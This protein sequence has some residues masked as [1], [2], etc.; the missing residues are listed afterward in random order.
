MYKAFTSLWSKPTTPTNNKI[1]LPSDFQVDEDDWVLVS[2]TNSVSKV[3]SPH[4]N[5]GLM[6]N[7]WIESPPTMR[8]GQSPSI[9]RSSSPN[10]HHFNPIENLLIEHA[11]MSVYEQIAS[12]TRA[13]R[14][15]K[16]VN[17]NKLDE[18]A[19]DVEDE[20]EDDDDDDRS[21]VV[22]QYPSQ[23][24]ILSSIH[25]RNLTASLSHSTNSSISP[26]E[27]ST[28]SLVAHHR[29]L[30]RIH[31]RRRRRSVKTS[32]KLT[33]TNN[34]DEQKQT[35]NK[36]IERQ[37]LNYARAPKFVLHQPSRSNH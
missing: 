30:H 32:S 22:L 10:I 33:L 18:Q 25:H 4:D 29:H 24:P 14:Q 13:R 8:S 37:R 16:T 21:S 15:R 23:H 5:N 35:I 31:Q 28:S 2:A 11:S 7:S 20:D 3:T 36:K 6:T 34:V 1:R 26:L 12:R 19:E 9:N 27:S 17:D